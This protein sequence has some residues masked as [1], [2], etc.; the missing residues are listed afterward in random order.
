MTQKMAETL[1]M[2]DLNKIKK[3]LRLLEEKE[4]E[5]QEPE[6]SDD[7]IRNA[8][9]DYNHLN[10]ALA[11]DEDPK[12]DSE[13]DLIAKESSDAS[14]DLLD[15]GMTVETKFTAEIVSASERFKNTQLSALKAK[16]ERK[17]KAID[18]R[19]KE[20]RLDLLEKKQ[21]AEISGNSIDATGEY[22]E[23]DR[24]KILDDDTLE[25]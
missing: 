12:F 1:G 23:D 6:Y 10:D 5:D 2:N 11:I 13:M 20:R 24:D 8:I 3:A 7:E 21:K 22:L 9:V 16:A 17:L 14:R 19:L 15:L 25:D 18:L 4:Q